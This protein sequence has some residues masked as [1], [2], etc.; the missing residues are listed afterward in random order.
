MRNSMRKEREPLF[1]MLMFSAK[2]RY[3]AILDW[4]LKPGPPAL[5]ASTRNHYYAI[6]EA[7]SFDQYDIKQT[8]QNKGL[9]SCF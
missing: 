4:G 5:E 9:N 6:E 1:P 7:V 3:D 8:H 2:Q